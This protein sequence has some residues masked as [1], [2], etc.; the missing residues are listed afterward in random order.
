MVH[1]LDIIKALNDEVKVTRSKPLVYIASPYTS[2]NVNRNVRAAMDAMHYLLTDGE[3]V[4]VSPVVLY[5]HLDVVYSRSYGD[6]LNICLDLLTKCNALVRIN[7]VQGEYVQEESMGADAEV[8][9]AK[10]LAIPVFHGIDKLESWL[11][12]RQI[13]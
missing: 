6:W 9:Y 1:G 3:C 4:P 12:S 5:H 8:V 7:A 11:G 13:A 10:T 2:G